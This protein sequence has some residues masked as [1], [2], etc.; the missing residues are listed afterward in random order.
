MQHQSGEK[1]TEIRN[2]SF[3]KYDFFPL[4]LGWLSF[5]VSVKIGNCNVNRLNDRDSTIDVNYDDAE[6]RVGNYDQYL[7]NTVI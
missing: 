5:Q 7:T 3:L 2:A 1:K 4:D 6:D